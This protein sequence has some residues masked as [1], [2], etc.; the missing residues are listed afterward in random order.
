MA[1]DGYRLLALLEGISDRAHTAR[2]DGALVDSVEGP[3][4]VQP[5]EGVFALVHSPTGAVIHVVWCDSAGVENHAPAFAVRRLWRG[6]KVFR[7]VDVDES[8][9]LEEQA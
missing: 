8:G 2:F 7:C 3:V 4:Q 5:D 6:E 9:G 1:I